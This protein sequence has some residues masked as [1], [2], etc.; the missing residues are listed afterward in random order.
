M[1][2]IIGV[3]NDSGSSASTSDGYRTRDNPGTMRCARIIRTT[4]GLVALTLLAEAANQNSAAPEILDV[5]SGG[6]TLRAQLWRPSGE[7]RFPAVLFNHGSYS[8]DDPLPPSDPET[9][10]SVFARHGYVFLWLHRQGIGMSS[11]EGI[12]DG[13]Q[14]ARALRAT[15]VEG[16]NRVQLQLLEHE[17]LNEAVAAL[18]RLRGRADV[19][20][21]LIGVVGHS[22]GGSLSVLMAARDPEI[23]AAVI[24]SGAAGSWNQSPALR[25]RLLAAVG[26]MSAPTL[27]IH[28]QNDYSTAPGAALADEMRRLGKPY[29]LKIYPPFGPD[30]RAGHNLIFRSVP[31]WESDVFAF[32]DAHLPR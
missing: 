29:V 8:T 32:L 14:M 23:R 15:G 21:R 11:G 19:Q 9:L 28:A 12:A 5:R 26:R 7:G 10:G 22:F 20:A 13:D 3:S 27:F 4:L 17:S 30:T 1:R 2:R 31:T 6:L 24:F 18:S 16:R 25:D